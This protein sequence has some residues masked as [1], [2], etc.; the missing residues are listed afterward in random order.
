[1]RAH[2]AYLRYVLRHKWHVFRACLALRVPLHQAIIHDW[3]KFLPVE[4]FPYVRQFYGHKPSEDEERRALMLGMSIRTR[5]EIQ[6][7]FDAAWNHHQ[8]TQPHHWQYWL[9]ITDQDEPRL[10]PLSI[11]QRF[12]LE[13]VADWWGAGMAINGKPEIETWYFANKDKMI[14]EDGTRF[15]VTQAIQKLKRK[16]L[17]STL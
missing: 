4:W 13:M 15:R 17:V 5:A 8:K 11:P 9:L 16:G 12:V 2:I 6:A 3:V 1:M 14:L 7:S 10:R